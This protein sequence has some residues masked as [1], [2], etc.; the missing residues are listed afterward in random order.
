MNNISNSMYV[1]DGSNN[2]NGSSSNSVSGDNGD[3]IPRYR[4]VPS[5]ITAKL[6]QSTDGMSQLTKNLGFGKF[7]E[8]HRRMEQQIAQTGYAF[9]PALIPAPVLAPA[10]AHA[11]SQSQAPAPAPAPEPAPEPAQLQEIS[12]ESLHHDCSYFP[13]H[14]S[15]DNL[16]ANFHMIPF[17]NS[18]DYLST[19]NFDD[20]F[21]TLDD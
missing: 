19:P 5:T 8:M 18:N 1:N 2:G 16:F 4:Y 12:T 14:S 17:L 20:L 15:S 10:P 9:S 3:M 11:S 6:A 13:S 7:L 21:P